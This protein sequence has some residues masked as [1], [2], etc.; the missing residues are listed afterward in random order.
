MLPQV[1]WEL[2][3]VDFTKLYQA[4]QK[5]QRQEVTKL[6]ILSSAGGGITDFTGHWQN[7]FNALNEIKPK[8]KQSYIKKVGIEKV[9]E[10]GKV[11][12]QALKKIRAKKDGKH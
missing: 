8:E 1:M 4:H 3:P 5:R 7:I 11:H 12:L 10:I 9:K 6:A 2:R